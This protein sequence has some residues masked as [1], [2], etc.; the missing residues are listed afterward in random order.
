MADE[1][2]PEEIKVISSKPLEPSDQALLT[3]GTKLFTDSVS[4][5]VDYGKTMITLISGFFAVYF[6]LLKFLGIETTSSE[7][8]Q[9]LPNIWWAPVLFIISIMIFAVGVV[10]PFPQSISLNDPASLKTT[11]KRLMWAKYSF[12]IVGTAIF[13]TGLGLT[14]G[15]YAALLR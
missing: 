5:T 7:L 13:L 14:L 9:S 1:K 8:F 12:A 2:K 4:I 6:A 10:L 3:F 15:I 11:R